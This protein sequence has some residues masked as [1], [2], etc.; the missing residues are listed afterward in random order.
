MFPFAPANADRQSKS[1]DDGAS[2]H[3]LF[4]AAV[5]SGQ[6]TFDA[7]NGRT[8]A[9]RE[10]QGRMVLVLCVL[11]RIACELRGDVKIGFGA[12]C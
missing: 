1:T 9:A 3:R 12:G 11:S 8:G 2:M 5:R 7:R 10:G 4:F 6:V